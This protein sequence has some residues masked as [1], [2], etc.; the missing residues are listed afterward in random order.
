LYDFDTINELV[1]TVDNDKDI[2]TTRKKKRMDIVIDY[3]LK[4]GINEIIPGRLLSFT[5]SRNIASYFANGEGFILSVDTSK[6]K[7]I[8]SE[9]TEP[10]LA[11]ADYVSEKK[12][13]EYIVK[14]PDS[15]VFKREDIFIEDLDYY[16]GDNN[17]LAVKYFDHNDKGAEY[18]MNNK[19]IYA[20]YYW[21]SNTSGSVKYY[22]KDEE[23]DYSNDYARSR[24]DFKQK[25]GFDPLPTI[26]NLD[27][28]TN[29]NIIFFCSIF[30]IFICP[31]DKFTMC[32]YN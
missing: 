28:I 18:T 14:I 25:Y 12:E 11:D 29:F 24:K 32:D 9:K 21:S 6:V 5:S 20:Q 7:I 2:Y 19:R 15:Y 31:I 4:N 3:I 10:L 30:G 22:I 13:K 26:D 16:V 1:A 27:K 17:P 23:D 8:T